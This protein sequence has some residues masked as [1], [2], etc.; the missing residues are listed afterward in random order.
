MGIYLYAAGAQRQ[1]ISVLNT[2]GI[3]SSY[4][5]I[6]GSQRAGLESITRS[7]D[8]SKHAPGD[9]D[10][11]GH[12]E[13]ESEIDDDILDARLFESDDVPLREQLSSAPVAVLKTQFNTHA[14]SLSSPP[15]CHPVEP[16]NNKSDLGT[17]KRI[18]I[19]CC[20]ATKHL[21]ETCLLGHVYDNINMVFKAGERYLR[22]SI[23]P[24]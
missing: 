22:Y 10:V 16:T 15:F 23:P 6:A 9:A 19:S 24:L 13:G 7:Q 12:S 14:T 20:A 1:V 18:S 4:P 8:G 2:L 5:A 21:A 3:C 17:L 11:A